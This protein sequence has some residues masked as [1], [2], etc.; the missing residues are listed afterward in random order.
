M[1]EDTKAP[2]F[3]IFPIP[4]ASQLD[5]LWEAV[6]IADTQGLDLV[7]IQD[8]PYQRRFV[9]T[10]ALLAAIAARTDRVTVFPDVASLP[11]RPPAVLAK[12]AATID[13]LSNGRF[14][15][16]LGAGAFWEAITAMGGPARSPGQA[17]QALSEAIDVVRLM[18]SQ[19]RAVRYDGEHYQLAGVKP[20]PPPAHDMEIWLG[21]YGP[22]ALRLLG[23]KAD[24]WVPSIPRMPVGELIAKNAAINEAAAAA[25][26]R[27]G[28]IRRICNVNGV[29]TDGP[30]DGYLRGPA[31]RWVDELSDLALNHGIDGF[32]LWPDGD[33]VEQTARFA[34]IA[35]QVRAA[36][37]S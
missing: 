4:D 11:L 6:R 22:R 34:Q 35:P 31:G 12:T 3:G 23:Q 21:V 2:L 19:E 5:T 18:W 33:V 20:G 1:I 27:P 13:V 25:G 29:I 7:G 36:I 14:E 30:S 8:H 16:G 24:G 15:L 37:G 26:R 9:D 10:F 17:L 32:V 28:S